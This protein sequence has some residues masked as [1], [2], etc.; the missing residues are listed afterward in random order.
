MQITC[1]CYA[2]QDKRNKNTMTKVSIV[3]IFG[4]RK[5]PI[6]TRTDVPIK[7]TACLPPTPKYEIS[8]FKDRGAVESDDDALDSTEFLQ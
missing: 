1:G 7:K 4:I 2:K 8:L 3:H 6:L 5:A